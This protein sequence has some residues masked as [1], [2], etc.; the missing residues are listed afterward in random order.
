MQVRPQL[1]ARRAVQFAVVCVFASTGTGADVQAQARAQGQPGTR[2]LAPVSIS[3]KA[4]RDPVEKSYRRMINRLAL[5]PK[6][7]LLTPGVPSSVSPSVL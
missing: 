3:A 7:V 6:Y 4:N 5:R 2:D 1:M